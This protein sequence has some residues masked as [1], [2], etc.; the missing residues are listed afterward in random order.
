VSV[1]VI[2]VA[3]PPGGAVVGVAAVVTSVV[4]MAAA[5]MVVPVAM[6]IVVVAVTMMVVL[7]RVLLVVV[8][9]QVPPVAVRL[10]PAAVAAADHALVLVLAPAGRHAVVV[11]EEVARLVHQRRV[12]PARQHEPLPAPVVPDDDAKSRQDLN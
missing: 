11:L 2:S 7:V 12:A 6:V 1:L 5:A 8:V 4:A 9:V 10:D 3:V